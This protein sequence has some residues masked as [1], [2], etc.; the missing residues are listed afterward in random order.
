MQPPCYVKSGNNTVVHALSRL[1]IASEP[2]EEVFFSE[3]LR[4]EL[5]YYGAETF[6]GLK[7][8]KST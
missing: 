5:Y 4:A 2:M 7:S 1:E 8:A 6:R 3:E